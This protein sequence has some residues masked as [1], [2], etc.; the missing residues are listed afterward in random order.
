MFH[1]YLGLRY[2]TGSVYTGPAP[3]PTAQGAGFM[4]GV[5]LDLSANGDGIDNQ[6]SIE[7]DSVFANNDTFQAA[8]TMTPLFKPI[9]SSA[10]PGTAVAFSRGSEPSLKEERVM[11]RYRSVSMGFGL[12]GVNGV[13]GAA[14][15]ADLANRTLDWLLDELTV[16]A[17]AKF[18][19]RDGKTAFFHA[20]AVSS[21][22]ASAVKYRWDFGDRSQ[23]VTTT[24]PDVTHRYTSSHK[25]RDARVEVTDSLGHRTVVDIDLG[26]H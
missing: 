23:I 11:F 12:E 22:G 26:H 3:K 9:G 24:G 8:D 4:S 1:G 20:S 19:G 18:G 21:A 2:E 16:T 6:T 13:N 10:A 14:A 5:Q 25:D 7:G 15:Q 17:T